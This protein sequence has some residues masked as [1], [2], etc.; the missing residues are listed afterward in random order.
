MFAGVIK[1]KTE[2]RL[3]EKITYTHIEYEVYATKTN[4]TRLGSIFFA[5]STEKC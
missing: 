2:S 5:A 3:N 1:I 4:R